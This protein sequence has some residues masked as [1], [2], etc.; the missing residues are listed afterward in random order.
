ME[1]YK[2]PMKI[3]VVGASGFIGRHLVARL[4]EQGRD[5]QAFGRTQTEA[6]VE[7]FEGAINDSEASGKALEGVKCVVYLVGKS[8]QPKDSA[9]DLES[10]RFANCDLAVSFASHAVRAGVQR[11]IFISTVG[12]NGASTE[13]SVPFTESKT[14][15]PHSPYA[16][17]KYEAEMALQE[18][19]ESS[20]ME[21][22]VVRP[23][24]VYG[25]GAQGNFA[26]LRRWVMSGVPL[27]F[28]LVKNRRSLISVHNLVD[29]IICCID[30]PKA[31]NQVFLAADGDDISTPQL[32]REVAAAM[33][34]SRLLL[35][36]PEKLLWM[37]AH[38][39]GKK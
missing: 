18:I 5:I 20:G 29:L 35:P 17:S 10:Y 6:P 23:P 32:L 11:F 13:G 21:L 2:P 26:R 22:V 19:A 7:F 16:L 34:L 1:I 24:L 28:A 27:P 4:L 30:H 12:V 31:A 33:G 8:P 37:V 36:V 14:P 3:L 38:A 9:A 15:A 25:P 39:A